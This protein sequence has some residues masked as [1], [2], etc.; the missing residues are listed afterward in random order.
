ML[1]HSQTALLVQGYVECL[2]QCLSELRCQH[3][4]ALAS[5]TH[6]LVHEAMRLRGQYVRALGRRTA[7][8]DEPQPSVEPTQE[9]DKVYAD[10]LVSIVCHA[11]C[12]L[13]CSSWQDFAH[14][15]SPCILKC[16]TMCSHI[17]FRGIA[18]PANNFSLSHTVSCLVKSQCWLQIQ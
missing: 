7:K 5:R 17:R 12:C 1:S 11:A 15:L 6:R 4:S 8:V 16:P 13:L 9:A 14:I 2:A 18:G 10:L 3:D